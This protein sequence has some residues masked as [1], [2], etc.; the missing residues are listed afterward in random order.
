MHH[1]VDAGIGRGGAGQSQGQFRVQNRQIG[2]QLRRDHAHL[3]GFPGRHDGYRR[4]FRTGAGGR[5]HLHQ[6]QALAGYF[7]DAIHVRQGLLARQQHGQQQPR[8]WTSRRPGQHHLS[9][10][11]AGALGGV[12]H[13]GFRR[14]GDHVVDHGHL[15]AMPGQVGQGRRQEAALVQEAIG[16]DAQ[17]DLRRILLA[18]QGA[19]LARRAEFRNDG[20]DS[21]EL[22]SVHRTM[23]Q[24]LCSKVSR[25]NAAADQ[26]DAPGIDTAR[27]RDDAMRVRWQVVM[28]DTRAGRDGSRG[29]G[30]A[31]VR[32][33][34]QPATQQ[35]QG[36]VGRARRQ[37][38][39]RRGEKRGKRASSKEVP[40][41]R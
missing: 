9:V 31:L 12:Q 33:G 16:D 13:D 36:S 41:R 3:G 20:R 2:V 24:E 21:L 4:H 7:P 38:W 5:R 29:V 22:E 11:L 37:E 35:E 19:E 25:R 40:G 27:R 14:I 10:C 6:R 1:G 18:Q 8:P 32:Q 28:F 15:P 30:H 17:P 26:H 39:R 23:H 34:I